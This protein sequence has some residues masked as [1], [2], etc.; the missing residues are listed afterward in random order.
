MWRFWAPKPMVSPPS[1][2]SSAP[3]VPVVSQP[4]RQHQPL[5]ASPSA[6][7]PADIQCASSSVQSS[8]KLAESPSKPKKPMKNN[9][10]H[11]FL[12][13][14]PG[15]LQ[16]PFW[17]PKSSKLT[18][19]DLQRQSRSSQAHPKCSLEAPKVTGNTP[20][21]SH[22]AQSEPTVNPGAPKI[23]PKTHK[24]LPK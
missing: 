14:Q 6:S 21:W 24:M 22:G 7:Q 12:L 16:H 23:L 19:S 10:F 18:P 8:S 1:P 9:G 15:C 11:L 5:P 4:P 20:T 2:Q 13:C 3:E 17:I